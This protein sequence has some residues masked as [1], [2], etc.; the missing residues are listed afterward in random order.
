MVA[1][2]E[3]HLSERPLP[4]ADATRLL[5]LAM[6]A[7][8]KTI[9]RNGYDRI[10]P[11][12]IWRKQWDNLELRI[13]PD[14]ERDMYFADVFFALGWIWSFM[15]EPIAKFHTPHK[16]FKERSYIVYRKETW[17][18]RGIGYIRL[19][20]KASAATGQSG[21]DEIFNLTSTEPPDMTEN[22]ASVALSDISPPTTISSA[23]YPNPFP[24]PESGVVLFFG[25]R[26]NLPGD[27]L[28]IVIYLLLS[29]LQEAWA[30]MIT[31]HGGTTRFPTTSRAEPNYG[32]SVAFDPHNGRDRLLY[33]MT[34]SMVAASVFGVVYYM[35]HEGVFGW[36]VSVVYPDST[37]A[38]IGRGDIYINH[39][40]QQA[41]GKVN[42]TATS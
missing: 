4:P 1:V 14:P 42:A 11:K 8:Y 16:G 31:N 13:V 40:Y 2:V 20:Y 3:G 17:G 39:P 33:P 25:T 38:N 19:G 27:P 7:Q 30:L 24:V 5:F 28:K 34:T 37:R 22:N 41:D 12:A 32:V 21:L 10:F 18:N 26:K 29:I 6:L 23:S 15:A 36:R 35:L 9:A